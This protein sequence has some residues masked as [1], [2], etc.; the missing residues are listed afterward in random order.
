MIGLLLSLLGC[1]P[2]LA[3]QRA[4]LMSPVMMEA[5]DEAFDLHVWQTRELMRGATGGSGAACGCM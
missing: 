3:H 5:E 1:A 2:L 4:V